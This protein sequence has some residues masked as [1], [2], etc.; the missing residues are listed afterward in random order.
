MNDKISRFE[1]G[2]WITLAIVYVIVTTWALI[3]FAP[4]VQR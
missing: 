4:L 1:S 2:V 3:T